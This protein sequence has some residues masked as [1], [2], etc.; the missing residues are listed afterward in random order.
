MGC[1][2]LCWILSALG[3]YLR[4]LPQLVNVGLSVLMF[5]SAIFYP[6]SALP[7]RWQPVLSLNPLVLVIEQ[8]R[9]VLVSGQ[10]PS[11]LYLCLGIPLSIV[12]SEL[13]F[14]LFQKARRGFAD[15]M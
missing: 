14:R 8:T 11:T 1:L 2:G 13:C 5:L 10:G 15:V 9:A 6:V 12:L 3:V 7:E 4:D